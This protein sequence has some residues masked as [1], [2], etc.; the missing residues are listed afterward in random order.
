MGAYTPGSAAAL[1][2]SASWSIDGGPSTDFV[3]PATTVSKYN[4]PY[5]N[6]S[7]LEPG[8]H[9]LLVTNKGN[10]S[11]TPLSFT[12]FYTKHGKPATTPEGATKANNVPK[13]VG[14]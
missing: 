5:F 3:I 13:I 9:R 2:G 12:Y 4:Q 11:T 1:A 14:G 7:G 6:V 8:P 10:A